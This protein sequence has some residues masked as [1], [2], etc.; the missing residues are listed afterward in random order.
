MKRA[1][2]R[3][4]VPI[5]P[6]PGPRAPGRL[7]LGEARRIPPGETAAG[8]EDDAHLIRWLAG[9]T[10]T[11]T[12]QAG[13]VWREKR[14]RVVAFRLGPDDPWHAPALWGLSR[15]PLTTPSG[16]RLGELFGVPKARNAIRDGQS[17]SARVVVLL[18]AV[19]DT[20]MS[21]LRACPP[22]LVT[23]IW[24]LLIPVKGL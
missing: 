12:S 22:A 6:E 17:L 8:P 24:T 1:A 11:W 5:A 23:P 15:T 7:R 20:R 2:A 18:D 21:G 14:G 19:S 4:I 9:K 10:V 16:A 3:A 13:G